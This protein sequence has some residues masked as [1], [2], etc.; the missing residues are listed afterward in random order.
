LE[1]S[2]IAVFIDVENLTQWVKN[3]GTERLMAD[4]STIGQVIVRRAYGVWSKSGISNFQ[5]PLNRLGFELIHSFHP[6]SGKNSADIQL[7]VDVM[8]H[9]LRLTDVDWFVLATGDS[10]FSP[11][12]RRLREM[13]KEVIGVGPRSPLSE[14]VKSSCSRYIHTDP[15]STNTRELEF[16]DAAEIVEAI[17]AASTEPLALNV[18]K[19][20]ILNVNSAF[21]EQ[22]MGFGSFSMFLKA[23]DTVALT[24]AHGSNTIWLAELMTAESPHQSNA[25]LKP[26]SREQYQ[27]LLRKKKWVTVPR[28]LL[29]LVG[30]TLGDLA[31][32]D[33]RDMIEE[34]VIRI[35][36]VRKGV[37]SADL[38]KAVALLYKAQMFELSDD[39]QHDSRL[40]KLKSGHEYMKEVDMA[41]IRRLMSAC[42]ENSVAFEPSIIRN[43]L[44]SRP[45]MPHLCAMLQTAEAAEAIV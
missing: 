16:D 19:H 23:I 36:S 4:I 32:L 37:T 33:K 26:G 21:N 18:L 24:L 13:G 42:T 10:D 11:L 20:G 29:E 2:K 43:L 35:A 5:A 7:T 17:L 15:V 31:P 22:E 14:S 45:S 1:K 25:D 44:F 41:L 8:E 6:V 12:F 30:V 27:A 34:L 9:A 3:D 28:E 40:L 39:T 38:R